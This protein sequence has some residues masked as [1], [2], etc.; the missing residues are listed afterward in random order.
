M[1]APVQPTIPPAPPEQTIVIQRQEVSDVLLAAFSAMG[2]A[3]SARFLL[4]LS[5]LGAFALAVMAL[6]Q[7]SVF[8]LVVLGMYSGLTVL[9]LV[10]LELNGKRQA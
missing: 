9:P 6:R 1:V 5:M 7:P 8:S 10:W 2:Y 4:F 3:V